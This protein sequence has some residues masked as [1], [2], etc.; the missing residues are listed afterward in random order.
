VSISLKIEN[1]KEQKYEEVRTIA[2]RD[3]RDRWIGSSKDQLLPHLRPFPDLLRRFSQKNLRMPQQGKSP[4]T[5]SSAL[6]VWM[7]LPHLR[8]RV[9]TVR[10]RYAVKLLTKDEAW[11]I[12]VNMAKPLEAPQINCCY[13]G[14]VLLP[15]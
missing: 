10:K 5:A 1:T 14:V 4:R 7:V 6:S 8:R 3:F 11:R 2:S 9:P 13:C 15:R 12:A